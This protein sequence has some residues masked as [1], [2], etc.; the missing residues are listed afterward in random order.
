VIHARKSVHLLCWTRNVCL[1]EEKLARM[2][3]NLFNNQRMYIIT[4]E[5]PWM[6][7]FYEHDWLILLGAIQHNNV[8]GWLN[9]HGQEVQFI[10]QFPL[11]PVG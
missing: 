10:K 9:I 8:V 7:N 3:D 11:I 4:Q 2:I 6:R 5:L 1:H